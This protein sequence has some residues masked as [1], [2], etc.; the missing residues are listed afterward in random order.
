M[1]CDFYSIANRE[2]AIPRFVKAIITEI[3]RCEVNTSDWKIDTIFW[4]E[5]HP[6]Y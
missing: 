6:V 5:G 3:E 4:V 1:Y 2:E